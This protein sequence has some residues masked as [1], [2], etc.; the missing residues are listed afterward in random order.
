[1]RM[2]YNKQNNKGRNDMT[3]RAVQTQLHM[4]P[5]L[6]KILSTVRRRAWGS[7]TQSSGTWQML[8]HQGKAHPFAR[9]IAASQST[10]RQKRHWHARK[11]GSRLGNLSR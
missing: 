1:M 7:D 9:V 11:A 10:A 2:N 8:H 3:D 4:D 6:K 5:E